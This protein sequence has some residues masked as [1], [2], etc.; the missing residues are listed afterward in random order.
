ML[1]LQTLLGVGATSRRAKELTMFC[2]T[3]LVLLDRN[4]IASAD[5]FQAITKLMRMAGQRDRI[6]FRDAKHLCESC[7]VEC[8]RTSTELRDHK[9]DHGC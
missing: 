6:A 1:G 4:C 9:T 8:K 3:Y 7:L 5:Y 2:D